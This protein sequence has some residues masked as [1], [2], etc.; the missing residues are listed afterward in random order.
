MKKVVL[1]VA[2]LSLGF[3]FAQEAPKLV[4]P[5]V[6]VTPKNSW[7]KAGLTAGV[8]MSDTKDVASFNVG[9]D[10]RAQYLFTAHFA[11][12]VASG[13]NH[14]FAK[15]EIEDFGVIPLAGFARYYFQKEGLFIG[16]DFGYGFLSNVENNDGG[17]Y[18]N[19]QIG[20]HNRDWN[21]Y[22]F[23]Q[24]TFTDAINIRSLGLGATYNIRFK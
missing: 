5:K 11:V 12:G 6:E 2:T 15:E 3:T 23:Y 7:F 19:P 8:P 4:I 21:F 9:V 24:N 22:G 14:F 10:V 20:Y 1:L 13:Y 17:L 16:T 18:I